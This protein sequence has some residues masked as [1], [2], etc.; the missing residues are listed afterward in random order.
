MSKRAKVIFTNGFDVSPV[1][2]TTDFDL[3]ARIRRVAERHNLISMAAAMMVMV[4]RANKL[5]AALF[6]CPEGRTIGGTLTMIQSKS[7]WPAD[8]N[9]AGV[10]LVDIEK[11]TVSYWGGEGFVDSPEYTKTIP[12][13]IDLME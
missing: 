10:F 5:P 13:V 7:F 1:V 11:K 9:Q 2:E 3:E 12:Q 8:G 6:N 4:S